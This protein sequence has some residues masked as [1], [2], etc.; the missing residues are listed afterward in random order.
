MASRRPQAEDIRR[1]ALRSATRRGPK[2][3]NGLDLTEA[4]LEELRRS[5]TSAR[6]SHKYLVPE[7]DSPTS[8]GAPDTGP[9]VYDEDDDDVLDEEDND[10]VARMGPRS[11]ISTEHTVRACT[12]ACTLSVPTRFSL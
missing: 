7:T 12:I 2:F 4:E 9:V 8:S 10:F 1:A 3:L 11:S 5:P 6:S